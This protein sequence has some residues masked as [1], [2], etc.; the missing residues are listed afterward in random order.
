[1]SPAHAAAEKNTKTAV[2]NRKLVLRRR[3]A[4]SR[5]LRQA[6]NQPF[7]QYFHRAVAS[8][9]AGDVLLFAL[10]S[11]NLLGGAPR[12]TLDPYAVL[13]ALPKLKY[14]RYDLFRCNYDCS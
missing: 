13:G 2:V 11:C 3:A 14:K 5:S 7:H 12:D 6:A 4:Q 8:V 9:P 10:M 1:M